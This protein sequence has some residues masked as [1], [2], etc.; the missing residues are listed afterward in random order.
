MMQAMQPPS[1]TTMANPRPPAKPIRKAA[2]VVVARPAA[3]AGPTADAS[4]EV[5]MVQ[6]P[7]HGAFPNLHVFPGG[8]VDDAD[9]TLSPF[10]RGLSDAAASVA[11]GMESGG[12]RYWVAA[13]RECFEECGVLLAYR[14]DSLFAPRDGA[15]EERFHGYRNAL[16]DGELALSTLARDEGLQLATDRMR[17]LSHWITPERVPARF[18]TR[19]FA[20][21]MP[22]GQR[23]VGH[24]EE[25]AGGVW[26]RPADALRHHDEGRWQM[27][28][29]T[30]TTLGIAARYASVETLL[31]AV[32]AGAHLPAADHVLYQQGMQ[33][34][35]ASAAP[36][37]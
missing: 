4:I 33:R 20:A 6:R 15:E 11:L 30:L 13:I 31:A 28:H 17:Y 19:F 23:A 12:L 7:A 34:A 9:A 32:A 36:E 18:D 24:H 21:A 25:T 37:S 27:I 14:G 2:T 1:Q 35:A 26:V 8:K 22:P 29:P 3:D 10:C 5:F 16:V